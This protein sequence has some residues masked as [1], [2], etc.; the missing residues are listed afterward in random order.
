ML[1]LPAAHGLRGAKGGVNGGPRPGTPPNLMYPQPQGLCWALSHK[2]PWMGTPMEVR[3]SYVPVPPLPAL[4]VPKGSHPK[5]PK[6]PHSTPTPCTLVQPPQTCSSRQHPQAPELSQQHVLPWGQLVSSSHCMSPPRASAGVFCSQGRRPPPAAG[7]CPRLGHRYSP[8]GSSA[9]GQGSRQPGGEKGGLEPSLAPPRTNCAH[10]C[11]FP[12]SPVP[13]SLPIPAWLHPQFWMGVRGYGTPS[14]LL[15][16]P[17]LG[18]GRSPRISVASC[19][20]ITSQH[21]MPKLVPVSREGLTGGPAAS[22][23]PHGT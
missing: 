23:H 14:S 15:T 19:L 1:V 7:S 5:N 3:V 22:P 18:T 11:L 4:L 2:V 6:S 17:A 21:W 12:P 9:H 20:L 10:S 8:G 13:F 16:L